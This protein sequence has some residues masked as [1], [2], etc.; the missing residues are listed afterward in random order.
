MRKHARFLYQT[1]APLGKDGRLVTG[2]K[3]H[4]N[5]AKEAVVE[6]TVLLK[7]NGALPLKPG[8]RV[9]LFGRG[10]GGFL[11]GGGGSGN[12][13]TDR[14]TTLAQ[15][16]Q[17]A[18]D[19]GDIQFFTPLVDFYQQAVQ[20]EY[21]AQQHLPRAQFLRW[22]RSRK[23]RMPIAPEE[24]YQQAKNF[25]GTAIFCVSRFS[26]EGTDYGDRSGEQGDFYLWDE[27][28]TLLDRLCKDFQQVVVVLNVCGPVSTREY[29]END[30]VGAVL[31]CVFGGGSSGDAI[32]DLLLGKRYPSGHL[33]DT[34]AQRIED[35]PSTAGYQGKLD[36]VEY[37]EDIFV[38]YRYFETFRPEAV[39]YPYGFG[40]GYTTFRLTKQSAAL[41][42]NTVRLSVAVK[43][44]GAFPGKEVVQAYL[45]APQGKLGKARKVL[46]AFEKTRELKPG[47]SYVV[48][49][50]FDIR[51]F[52]SYDDTGAIA[53]HTFLL[54]E[55][56]YTLWVGNN[57]RDT[58]KYLAFTLEENLICRRCRDYM[59]PQVQLQRLK[60]DGSTETIAASA[61]KAYPV[62]GYTLKADPPQAPLSLA[63]ALE[64]GQL[65]SFIAGLS[66]Q[67]LTDLLYGH[68]VTCATDTNGIGLYPKEKWTVEKI[69]LIPTADGP[70]G[71]RA[72]VGSDVQATFFPSSN[73]ISQTWNLKLAK[74]VA[75]TAALEFKENNIGMWLAPGMNI[76][77]SP[78]CG[79]N[80][81]YYSEDP[82]ATG[83][84]A[85][86]TVSGIQSRN[87]AAT[88]KH[89]CCNNKEVNRKYCDSRLSQRAL[90]EIYLRGFEIVVKKAKPWAL[91]TSYNP[92]NG[93]QASTNREAINGI[94]RGEWGYEGLVVTDWWAFS[95]I[96]DELLAG[97]DVKM[98][99]LISEDFP[100]SPKQPY[101]LVEQLQTGRLRRDIC[102]AAVKRILQ[103][104]GHLE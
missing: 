18:S 32:T 26:S 66:D 96:E 60:A 104:M 3:A 95:N 97:S 68:P 72:I 8:S 49:L 78:L 31:Y 48:Q 22:E 2:S 58:E 54:E 51:E 36:H 50:H 99:Q 59:A 13:F 76:H 86:A 67:D 61:P 6:G 52:G 73:T 7:N 92:I 14:K 25:G 20:A 19:A 27:E 29:K 93:V 74:K 16:L 41:E 77:R 80:F 102:V 85:A 10:A 40:L 56:Q 63:D 37:T 69:P 9:C 17:K 1:V 43:N 21:D 75:A 82:L 84:F 5:V 42:K 79:R 64:N 28:Q 98:P 100:G 81:E 30:S 70:A 89:F 34:L 83:L 45:Q 23:M 4:Y 90:R 11:F 88:V 94:L 103:F 55:G 12:V 87:I 24:L 15:G 47:E 53:K 57:V 62:K 33:Q 44:T 91:M 71:L 35:Y 46:C 65:D 101:S 39:V 38:G